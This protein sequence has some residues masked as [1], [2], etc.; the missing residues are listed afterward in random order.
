M[1]LSQDVEEVIF[2]VGPL[3][4]AGCGNTFPKPPSSFPLSMLW[5]L[6]KQAFYFPDSV[7]SEGDQ[8][9]Q[10]WPM[11]GLWWEKGGHLGHS[12][13]IRV[14]NIAGGRHSFPLFPALKTEEM[15]GAAAATLQT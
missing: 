8:A 13:L 4:H 3:N 1:L 9:P 15:S 12:I 6:D 7:A 2:Y 11:Q 10:C 14:K 5:S